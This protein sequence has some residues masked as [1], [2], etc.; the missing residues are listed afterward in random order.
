ME[1]QETYA[2]MSDDEILNVASDLA[3]LEEHA[4]IAITAELSQRQLSETDIIQYRQRVASFN[5]EDFWG[6]DEHIARSV[7]GCGTSLYGRRGFEPDGSFVTTKWIVVFFV[8]AFPLASM[9]V[10][11][12][13]HGYL[14]REKQR[15]RLK[16]VA[17]VYSYL[18]LLLLTVVS[19][20]FL[21]RAAT[22]VLLAVVLPLPWFLRRLARA[23]IVKPPRP[24]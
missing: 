21:P 10:K 19:T 22:A 4:R 12:I 3:S 14:V 16:Q 18:L 2:A 11:V 15:P 5:P 8:P 17:C 7:N 23:G 1:Y 13:E 6:K 24:L 20:D 9:R